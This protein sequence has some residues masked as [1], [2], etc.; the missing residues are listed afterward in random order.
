MA[1]RKKKAKLGRP[2]GKSKSPKLGRPKAAK[3]GRWKAKWKVSFECLT[4]GDVVVFRTA[5]TPPMTRAE[6]QKW[7]CE[8][9]FAMPDDWEIEVAISRAK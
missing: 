5:T 4:G 6:A 2:P 8:K 3:L 7:A 9:A 1:K